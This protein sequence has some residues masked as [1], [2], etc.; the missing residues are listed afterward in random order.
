MG[1]ERLSNLLTDRQHLVEAR[2]R[3]LK[4]HRDLVASDR[5]HPGGGGADQLFPVQLDRSFD[6][7]RILWQEL[8]HRQ[9]RHALSRTALAGDR[10]RFARMDIEIEVANDGIELALA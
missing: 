4:D 1:N 6:L 5:P 8:H 9:R 7:T 10:K 3:L 2:Y